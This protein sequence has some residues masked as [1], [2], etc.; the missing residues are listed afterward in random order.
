[1]ILFP[2]LQYLKNMF[3]YPKLI[4]QFD[5]IYKSPEVL[6]KYNMVQ[7]K[8]CLLLAIGLVISKMK[9]YFSGYKYTFYCWF[10][11]AF[12]IPL[13]LC[14]HISGPYKGIINQPQ[15]GGMLIDII[16]WFQNEGY[17]LNLLGFI[18]S[19]SCGTLQ[20]QDLQGIHIWRLIK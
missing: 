10:Y 9:S 16:R 1:M 3:R 11:A 15:T 20:K 4:P 12:E 18:N 2:F 5:F 14:F 6:N 19:Y 13:L 7:W 8:S 17:R